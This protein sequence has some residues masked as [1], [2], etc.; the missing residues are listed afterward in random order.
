MP[1]S[2]RN[3][4]AYQVING[5]TIES[6]GSHASLGG[7]DTAANR[8]VIHLSKSPPKNVYQPINRDVNATSTSKKGSNGQANHTTFTSQE[9]KAMNIALGFSPRQIAENP[10]KTQTI[11]QIFLSFD[12]QQETLRLEEQNLSGK[13]SLVQRTSNG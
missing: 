4:P 2:S 10:A 3:Y 1:L 11:R 8:K 7:F 9:S 6:K 12:Q 5:I 13:N